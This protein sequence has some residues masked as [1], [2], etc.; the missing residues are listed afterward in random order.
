MKYAPY[1]YSSIT[2]WIWPSPCGHKLA[3]ILSAQVPQLRIIVMGISQNVTH[4]RRQFVEQQWGYFVV[5]TVGCCQLSSQ[6][7]P[8]PSYG[9]CQVKLP[10]IPPS[11]PSALAPSC[12]GIDGCMRNLPFFLMFFVPYSSASFQRGAI[13]CC[14]SSVLGEN[15]EQTNKVSSKTT[16]QPRQA[17]RQSGKTSLSSATSR[18]TSI[19][20]KE[21]AQ[22]FGNLI[23]LLKKSQQGISSV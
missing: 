7:Y 14:C 23:L 11:L 21:W 10:S 2:V 4:L 6:P 13:N 12:F 5:G 20:K 15:I 22:L 1:F 9:H 18:E 8:N 19:L 16:D 3:S 17:F